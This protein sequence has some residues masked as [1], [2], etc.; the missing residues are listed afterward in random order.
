LAVE[1]DSPN[2]RSRPKNVSTLTVVVSPD[3]FSLTP[4]SSAMNTPDPQHPGLSA[5]QVER[6]ETSE[7]IGGD[8][9]A[10]E[11]SAEGDIQM[12]YSSD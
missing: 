8:P 1:E 7:N 12:K 5:C 2:S 4:N 10:P 3:P 9:D 6:E 11:L